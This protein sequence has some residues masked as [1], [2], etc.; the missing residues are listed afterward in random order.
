MHVRGVQFVRHV[1]QKLILEFQLLL[2]GDFQRTQQ[3]L[4]FYGITHGTF[5]LLA[6]N[7]PLD[8]VVLDAQVYGLHGQ[9]LVVLTGQDHHRHIGRLF[10]DLS[11]SFRA[12][13]VGQVQI[14]QHHRRRFLAQTLQGI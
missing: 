13:A 1:R 6:G 3:R 11:E 9:R 7:V 4:P 14:Q 8:Q 10:H 12:A 5:Q 2:A